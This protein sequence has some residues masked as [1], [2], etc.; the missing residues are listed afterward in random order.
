MTDSF[1]TAE[2]GARLEVAKLAP[3]VVATIYKSEGRDVR[4]ITMTLPEARAM[5]STLQHVI[6]TDFVS[7]FMAE[8]VNA[9]TEKL[10][11]LF[12]SICDP[13]DWKAPIK[14]YVRDFKRAD[15][16][17]AIVFY[18]ATEAAFEDAGN[19]WLKVTAPGYRMGP[20]GDH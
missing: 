2:V 9:L 5:V 4:Q 6:Q 18:T 16:A 19:G 14:A 20:A 17:E 15:I 10:K 8:K 12:D 3:V 11:P 1:N 13:K 7:K